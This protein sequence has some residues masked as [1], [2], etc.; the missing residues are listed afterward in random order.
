MCLQRG[1]LRRPGVPAAAGG[2]LS[3]ALCRIA[4]C[5]SPLSPHPCLRLAAAKLLRVPQVRRFPQAQLHHPAAACP[6]GSCRW[7]SRSR[8]SLLHVRPRAE[9][10]GGPAAG[11]ALRLPSALVAKRSSARPRP[12]LLCASSASTSAA[13]SSQRRGCAP[14][15]LPQKHPAAR[16]L[17]PALLLLPVRLLLRAFHCPRSPI[18]DGLQRLRASRPSR[19]MQRRG[20]G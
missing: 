4:R 3:R 18:R 5:S 13:T 9:R 11:E 20:G 15:L 12:P 8:C 7:R 2:A 10:C 17:P 6:R 14:R 19:P 16:R 1:Q